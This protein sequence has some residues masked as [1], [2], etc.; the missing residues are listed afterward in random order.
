MIPNYVKRHRAR[1]QA[2]K[3]SLPSLLVAPGVGRI[4]VT[5]AHPHL[6]KHIGDGNQEHAVLLGLDHDGR[7]LGS[8]LI[9]KGE[10]HMTPMAPRDV[11]RRA[12]KMGANAVIIA[13]NH[14]SGPIS[15]S[16]PDIES[17]KHMIKAGNMVQLPV[18]DHLIFN[19]HEAY[20]M[21][22]WDY[23]HPCW[24]IPKASGFYGQPFH[25]VTPEEM[26]RVARDLEYML[27]NPPKK[28]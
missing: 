24:T 10:A 28:G 15:P 22:E 18:V 26:E 13:H 19:E 8:E 2:P 17:T 27:K 12:L 23:K 3:D 4:S 25:G 5:K 9:H 7:L 1:I 20:S 14:P 16:G 11:F 21:R 6:V